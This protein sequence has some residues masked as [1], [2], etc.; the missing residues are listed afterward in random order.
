[1][2]ASTEQ[3]KPPVTT[4][5]PTAAVKPP[6]TKRNPKKSAALSIWAT[7]KDRDLY[8]SV[9]KRAGEPLS[10]V[11]R[12]LMRNYDRTGKADGLPDLKTSKA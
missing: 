6:R 2:S 9:S 8:R 3:P 4:P 12:M 10:R 11:V 1:M 5:A 7:V